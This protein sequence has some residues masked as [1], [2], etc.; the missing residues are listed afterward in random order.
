MN[1]LWLLLILCAIATYLWRGLGTLLAGS[2]RLDSDLFRWLECVAYA[3]VTGLIARMVVMPSGTLATTPL[4]ERLLACG[5]ALLCYRLSGRNL[6]AS[7]ALGVAVM[8]G[9]S[10]WRGG[11]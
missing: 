8:V 4:T 3:M 11:V 7:V 1:E 2:I 5:V 10:Y 9:A 6:F